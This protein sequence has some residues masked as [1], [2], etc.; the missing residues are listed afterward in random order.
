MA[1]EPQRAIPITAQ[2][3]KVVPEK[4]EKPNIANNTDANP[5][6]PGDKS[7]KIYSKRVENVQLKI[8]ETLSSWKML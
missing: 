5:W 6:D 7:I 2:H 1:S 3:V 8:N 4:P